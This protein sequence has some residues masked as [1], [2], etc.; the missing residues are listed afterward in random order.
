MSDLAWQNKNVVW[1]DD[2]IFDKI[3]YLQ[4]LRTGQLL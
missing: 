2:R 4:Q 3:R 1:A